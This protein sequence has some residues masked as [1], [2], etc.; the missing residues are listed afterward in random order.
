MK[1]LVVDDCSEIL[2]YMH[3]LLTHWGHQ[4]LAL[5][6]NSEPEAAEILED[7]GFLKFDVA[8]V[9]FNML[10]VLGTTLAVHINRLSPSTKVIITIEPVPPEEADWLRRRGVA[11][12][13][14]P[15]PFEKVDLFRQLSDLY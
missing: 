11:F 10:G 2:A 1:L 5:C 3:K 4:V 12:E 15:A 13:Q 6:C 14:L 7:V 9:G 8:L